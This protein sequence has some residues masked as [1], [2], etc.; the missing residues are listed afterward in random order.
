[1]RK[2]GLQILTFLMQKDLDLVSLK[3]IQLKYQIIKVL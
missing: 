1:M 2:E 3:V